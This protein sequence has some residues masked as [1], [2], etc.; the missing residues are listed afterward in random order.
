M[1]PADPETVCRLADAVALGYRAGVPPT[2][3]AL[4][5]TFPDLPDLPRLAAVVQ[6]LEVAASALRSRP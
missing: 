2:A 1:T 3:D 6:A 4:R 5:Q